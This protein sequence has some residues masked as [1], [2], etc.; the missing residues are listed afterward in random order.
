MFKLLLVG[1]G[2]A[3]AFSGCNDGLEYAGD[4]P[5]IYLKANR[6]RLA[7]DLASGRPA[8]RRFLTAVDRWVDGADYWGFEAWNAALVGQLTGDPKYCRAAVA[9]VDAQVRSAERTGWR[10]DT[11]AAADDSYL[12]SGDIIGNLALV[13]DWCPG[14]D[15]DR[16]RAWASYAWQTVWN[17]W[18]PDDAQWSNRSRPWT[19]W[20]IDN[21]GNNYYSSFLRATMLV[22]LAM[23]GEIDGPAEWLTEVRDVHLG[24]SDCP[25][26]SNPNCFSASS[27]WAISL[28]LSPSSSWAITNS[29]TCSLVLVSN[30]G[31]FRKVRPTADSISGIICATLASSPATAL[32]R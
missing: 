26:S 31:G 22:S 19:G 8:A 13:Y 6:D 15:P 1:I 7:A 18:H 25:S 23:Q 9:A 17:I 12:R 3:T 20:S 32:P 29:R 21:P 14:I 27:W 10:G 4:H 24:G 16:R 2:V 5:R 11:P 30:A 28:S